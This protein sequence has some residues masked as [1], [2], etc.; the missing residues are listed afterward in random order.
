MYTTDNQRIHYVYALCDPRKYRPTRHARF[1]LDYEPFY[2]GFGKNGRM[3][4][5]VKYAI[6][7]GKKPRSCNNLKYGRIRH[8]HEDGLDVIH[9]RLRSWLTRKDAAKLEVR[10]I[11]RIG[12]IDTKT[13]PLCNLT[14]GGEGMV[15]VVFTR[16]IR[17]KMRRAH[18]RMTD[19]AKA[20]R[21]RKMREAKQNR[22]EEAREAHNLKL[23]DAKLRRT[24][25]QREEWRR[26]CALTIA[27]KS[28]EEKRLTS[29]RQRQ[30]RLKAYEKYGR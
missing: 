20:E 24:A 11:Q 22:T 25:E 17:K 10:L 18:E 9:V 1:L 4:D 3:Y 2:I 28:D 8:I 29:L 21:S 23:A 7:P 30:S 14:S 15:G 5:H 27:A 16:K 12:R 19:E 6:K 26:K 13:G